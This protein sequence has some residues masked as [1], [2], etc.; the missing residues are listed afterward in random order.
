MNSI[1]CAFA[2]STTVEGRG[3]QCDNVSAVPHKSQNRAAIPKPSL[4]ILPSEGL[5]KIS[6]TQR[7]CRAQ[8]G[9]QEFSPMPCSSVEKSR[10]KDQYCTHRLRCKSCR[11][12]H[13][14]LH[15][16]RGGCTAYTTIFVP[17][18]LVTVCSNGHMLQ[19]LQLQRLATPAGPLS[20]SRQRAGR[21]SGHINAQNFAKTK[22][23]STHDA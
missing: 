20:A 22:C 5:N 3:G 18:N 11:Y 2:A 12:E 23:I 4:R 10:T 9:N 8:H 6:S 13:C 19:T 1:R 21:W 17:E 7:L 15:A 16:R 14:A